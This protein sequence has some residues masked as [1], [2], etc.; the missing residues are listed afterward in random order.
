MVRETDEIMKSNKIARQV[1]GREINSKYIPHCTLM[2]VDI[3]LQKK[4]ETITEIE[5]EMHFDFDLNSIHL[6]L[7]NGEPKDWYIV[8]E[9]SLK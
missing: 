5:K 9:F 7:T 6:V 2:Y 1:F 8:K 3:S 4:E